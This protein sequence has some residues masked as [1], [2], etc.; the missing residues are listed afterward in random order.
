[1]RES[2]IRPHYNPNMLGNVFTDIVPNNKKRRP[3]KCKNRSN[4]TRYTTEYNNLSL[5]K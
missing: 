4:K 2:E 1:M 5:E 3:L